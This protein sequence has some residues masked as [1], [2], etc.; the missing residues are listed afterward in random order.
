MV[1]SKETQQ[2]RR[3]KRNR[4]RG[5]QAQKEET[6]EGEQQLEGGSKFSNYMP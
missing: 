6:Q 4:S 5:I 2:F 3:L 1:V